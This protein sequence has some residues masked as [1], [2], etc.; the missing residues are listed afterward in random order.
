M[1]R[2]TMYEDEIKE[3]ERRFLAIYLE[4]K[5]ACMVLLSEGE[6]NLGTLAVA[7]PS[8]SH[9]TA[10]FLSSILMGDRNTTTARILAERLASKINKIGLVSI[11]LKTV[12]EAEASPILMRL[13]EKIT[14]PKPS[15]QGESIQT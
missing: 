2:A 10:P 1:D 6:D 9:I 5:N 15:M 11:Y 7:I 8:Q 4:S 3:G 14:Q 12:S 13:F